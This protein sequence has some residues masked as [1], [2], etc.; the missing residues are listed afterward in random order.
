[1]DVRNTSNASTSAEDDFDVA[2]SRTHR[3]RR[4]VLDTA[5]MTEIAQLGGDWANPVSITSAPR[6]FFSK[7]GDQPVDSGSNGNGGVNLQIIESDGSVR[8]IELAT[9]NGRC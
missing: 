2:S 7:G 4:P 9:E 5:S 3:G 8:L 6:S 1:M